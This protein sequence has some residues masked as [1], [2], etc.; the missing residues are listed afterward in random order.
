MIIA[1]YST[2]GELWKGKMS[3]VPRIGEQIRINNKK[4]YGRYTV[5]SVDWH[6]DNK[7]VVIDVRED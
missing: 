4:L 1:I 3:H 5:L 6:V 7:K 2:E